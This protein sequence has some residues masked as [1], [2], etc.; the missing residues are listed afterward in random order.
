MASDKNTLG[1][2]DFNQSE[3]FISLRSPFAR[4]VRLALLENQISY[5]EIV[6]DVF[7][8]SAE[9]IAVNP[10]I[11]VP[12]LRLQS[13][14]VLIDSNLILQALYE[15][16]SDSP[17]IP[18]VMPGAAAGTLP[19]VTAGVTAGTV[20]GITSG[21]TSRVVPGETSSTVPPRLIHFR[22]QAIVTGFMEKTV[23]Y[24]L[25]TQRPSAGQDPEI[26]QELK[27]MADRVMTELEAALIANPSHSFILGDS[28]TQADLDLASVLTYFSLRYS[29]E[30]K[31]HYPRTALYLAKLEQRPSLVKTCPPGIS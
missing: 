25:E 8:P 18:G 19:G 31:K 20:P 2:I 3:L 30:W 22:W 27:S 6:C 5:K 15:T 24:F 4:R 1:R 9:L 26:E 17:L 11:R 12:V 28:L 16:L 23:E 10:L 14:A 13:G 7:K 21:A 29:H